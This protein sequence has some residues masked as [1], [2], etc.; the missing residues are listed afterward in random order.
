MLSVC[1]CLKGDT[2]T[3]NTKV[4]SGWV[5][6][7]THLMICFCASFHPFPVKLLIYDPFLCN[8]HFKS[9]LSVTEHLHL[10]LKSVG[11]AGASSQA[12]AH[13]FSAAIHGPGLGDSSLLRTEHKPHCGFLS[14][15]VLEQ[16][17]SW[18]SCRGPALA[19]EK[20][21]AGF[22]LEKFLSEWSIC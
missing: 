13:T 18:L 17:R 8:I 21:P 22:I 1:L 7:L 12:S 11:A 6:A 5:F 15:A 9:S 2:Y 19:G 14:L 10:W 4:L 3:R 16:C 20:K